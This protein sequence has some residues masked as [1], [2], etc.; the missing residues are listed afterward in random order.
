MRRKGL[1]GAGGEAHPTISTKKERAS[2][3]FVGYNVHPNREGRGRRA[4]LVE[5]DGHSGLLVCA[6]QLSGSETA[7]SSGCGG[8]DARRVS[9]TQGD[10]LVKGSLMD[11]RLR[12]GRV[13]KG[14]AVKSRRRGDSAVER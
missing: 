8:L 10:H 14:A 3:G 6:E 1:I 4:I 11:E 9:G 12:R 7:P 13:Q 2:H 5:L